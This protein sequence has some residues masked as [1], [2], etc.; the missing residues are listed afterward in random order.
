METWVDL[1][2]TLVCIDQCLNFLFFRVNSCFEPWLSTRWYGVFQVKQGV[3]HQG[4]DCGD[5]SREQ[6]NSISFVSLFT[7]LIFHLVLPLPGWEQEGGGV[8]EEARQ[9]DGQAAWS[10]SDWNTN[11]R[12]RTREKRPR[13]LF[14]KV[15][16]SISFKL[17][18]L[19]HKH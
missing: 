8:G 12:G 19:L 1:L 7:F 17:T 16:N 6:S 13:F 15:K 10:S 5:W 18:M 4:K 11:S 14:S 2:F 9:P 3:E